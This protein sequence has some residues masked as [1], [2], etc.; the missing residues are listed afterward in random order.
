MINTKIWFRELVAALS[1]HIGHDLDFSQ[2]MIALED[3]RGRVMLI[4]EL[5]PRETHVN[6]YAPFG[7]YDLSASDADELTRARRLLELN[8]DRDDLLPFV[9]CAD[10]GRK[11]YLLRGMVEQGATSHEFIERVDS[12]VDRAGELQDVLASSPGADPVHAA[13]EG[14]NGLIIRA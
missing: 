3:D 13:E 5:S 7:D 9:A 10:E 4:V 6:L 14:A 11:E 2:D 8:A 12:I 1:A